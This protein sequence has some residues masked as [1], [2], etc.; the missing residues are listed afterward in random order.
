MNDPQTMS[1]Y[2]WF[3][4]MF[5]CQMTQQSYKWNEKVITKF[6]LAFL[7]ASEEEWK[8]VRVFPHIN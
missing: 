3:I 6:D 5:T 8:L 7:N 1:E 2:C 4:N